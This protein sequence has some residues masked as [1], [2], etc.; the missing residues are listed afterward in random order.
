MFALARDDAEEAEYVTEG[1]LSISR[2]Y[3]RILFDIGATHSFIS[4]QFSKVLHDK[5]DLV[6]GNLDVHLIVHTP[7]GTLS[8]SQSYPSIHVL[9]DG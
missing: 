9:M 2:Y 6:A 8:I 5:L 3:A 1:T 4:E 7:T